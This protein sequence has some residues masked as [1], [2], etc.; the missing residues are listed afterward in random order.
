M[1]GR[2]LPR[3]CILT[4]YLIT[5]I[6]RNATG[7]VIRK[8]IT[9]QRSGDLPLQRGI[10]KHRLSGLGFAGEK[11]AGEALAF[12]EPLG[13]IVSSEGPVIGMLT[14]LLRFF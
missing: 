14:S 2:P 11:V 1:A 4:S 8:D 5:N 6:D 9:G 13:G 3:L 12:A 10:Q 7:F